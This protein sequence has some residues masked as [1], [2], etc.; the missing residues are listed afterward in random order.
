MNVVDAK[1]MD[2]ERVDPSAPDV[3]A[4]FVLAEHAYKGNHLPNAMT[5]DV[6]DYFQ[7]SA[8]ENTISRDAW[9]SIP[10]RLTRNIGKALEIFDAAGIHATFFTLGWVCENYPEVVKE[11]AGAGHEIASHGHEHSRVGA[12]GRDKFRADVEDTRKRLEDVSGTRVIGYRAPSFSIGRET[13]WAHDELAEAGYEYSSSVFPISHDHYG[14]PE[15][16]RFPFR[17]GASGILEIP[18]SSLK[19]FGRNW[20]CSGGGYFRL[21][22]VAYSKWAISRINEVEQMPAVFYFHPWELDPDQPKVDGIPLKARFRHY[23]NLRRF[24]GRLRTMLGAFRWD[25]MDRVFLGDA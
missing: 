8:F 16:P 23:L 15:A 2:V 1:D 25:R 11:I 18:M 4:G 9:R 5:I 21:M 3:G 24:E 13:L 14:L 7:V 6:E 22:P 10:S 12:L 19:F 17:P 20:P